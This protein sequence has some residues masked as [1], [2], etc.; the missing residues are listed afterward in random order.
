MRHDLASYPFKRRNSASLWEDL[1]DSTIDST[2]DF[3]PAMNV[4]RTEKEVIIDVEVPGVEKENINIEFRD[5]SLIISGSRKEEK[6]EEGDTYY[7][8]ERSTGRFLRKIHF[9]TNVNEESIKASLKEGILN[10][11]IQKSTEEKKDKK[12]KIEG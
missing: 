1:F 5:N 8:M 6:Q 9:E 12:I 11:T 4:K 7:R 10:I 3:V 2:A